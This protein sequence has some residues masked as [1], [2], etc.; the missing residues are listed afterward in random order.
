MR[1]TIIPAQITTVEDKI[2]GDLTIYQIFL[3]LLPI[4]FGGFLYI[5]FPPYTQFVEYKI[6]MFLILSLISATLAVRVKEKMIISWGIV[7]L[8][9]VARPKY[10]VFNKN[11]LFLREVIQKEKAPVIQQALTQNNVKVEKIQQLEDTE[12]YRLEQ[13]MT[14]SNGDI[15]FIFQKKGGIN[16]SFS[17]IQ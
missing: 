1:T 15:S 14:Q 17:K 12:I 8:R 16:V 10:F 6:V 2:A 7:L 4:F 5:S 9:F 3:L 11:D 13:L